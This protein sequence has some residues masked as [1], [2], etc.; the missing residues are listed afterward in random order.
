MALATDRV[1]AVAVR[2][3]QP[4]SAAVVSV[5][6]G[7]PGAGEVRLTSLAVGVCGTDAD[8]D[9]GQYGAAPPGADQLVIGHE[10]L[11]RVEST[12]PGVTGWKPGDLAV[13]I[14]RRPCPELCPPCAAGRWDLCQ[15]GD[16][17]ERGINGLD[18]FLRGAL[19]VEADFL[20]HVP[21]ELAPVAVLTEPLSIVEK[22][23]DVAYRI[24]AARLA[25]RPRRAAVTGAGPVGLLG[26]FLL[27][28]RG[29]QVDVF[30]RRPAGSPKARLVEAAGG[31]YC[32]DGATPIDKAGPY[33]LI[34]EATGYAPLA[35]RAMN[36]LSPDGILALTGV[37]SGHHSLAVDADAINQETVL[38]N[39]VVFGSVNAAREHYAAAVADLG[40][41]RVRWGDLT[42]RLITAR[43]PLQ[44]FR[45]AFD[46]S[47]DDVKSIVEI[48][49]S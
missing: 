47:P 34:V 21:A 16:F 23:V 6:V 11:L 25:W 10:S 35:F 3:G 26:A 5:E 7:D 33:D 32:D 4:R 29:L 42:Q 40:D 12:G 24:Q 18:G 28:S 14:V 41:W 9:A 19:V 17:R 38:E 36:C 30:D 2:P 37:T 46:K 44:D 1:P 22:A 48:T 13:G 45:A 8:I 15:T 43:H 20:V 31:R 39:H 49:R 27:L